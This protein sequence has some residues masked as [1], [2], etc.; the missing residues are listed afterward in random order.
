MSYRRTYK[1]LRHYLI[2]FFST[3]LLI[4]SV[5]AP[6]I[7]LA[8]AGSESPYDSGYDHGC[9]DAD[10]SDPSDRYINEPGKGPS[11]HTDE[12]MQGYYAGYND[13]SD[14]DRNSS[15]G[16]QTGRGINWM[17]ICNTLQRALYSSCNSLVN[18]DGTLTS[19]GNRALTC[20]RNGALLAAA[21]G[22]SSIP[23]GFI[24]RGLQ[25]LEGP[26]GCAGIVNWNIVNQIA[27]VAT[28]LNLIP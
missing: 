2:A 22:L 16:S 27:S 26:T 7:Q 10:I 5:L 21:A 4:A 25:T 3:T 18:S 28:I 1:Y 12:F 20:I 13:C 14:V 8:D 9:D 17:S 19:E 11:F 15:S 6:Q 24:A 23:P